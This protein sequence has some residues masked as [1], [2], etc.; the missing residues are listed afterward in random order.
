[1]RILSSVRLV[2]YKHERC[3]LAPALVTGL[4]IRSLSRFTTKK[5]PEVLCL[6]RH[7]FNLHET[8]VLSIVIDDKAHAVKS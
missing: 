5:L 2:F 7:V 8:T 3:N 6:V 4:K 1:M